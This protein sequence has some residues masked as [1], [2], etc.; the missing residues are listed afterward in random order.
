MAHSITS[1]ILA[2]GQSP[3]ITNGTYYLPALNGTLIDPYYCT[4]A[5]CP[6]QYGEIHYLPSFPGN[7]TYLS[8]F[9]ILA[10]VHTGLGWRHKTWGFMVG[11]ICGLIL[12]VAGYAGRLLIHANDFNFNYFIM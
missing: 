10:I 8:I 2:R 12:E 9:A 11:M 5:I 7:V 4:N 3:Q 1:T 6:L